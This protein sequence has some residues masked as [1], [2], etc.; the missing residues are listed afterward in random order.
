[1]VLPRTTIPGHGPFSLKEF[2]DWLSGGYRFDLVQ[3]GR[4]GDPIPMTDLVRE[5]DGFFYTRAE[6]IEHYGGTDEWDAAG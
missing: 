1:M 6:F 4:N 2:V 3:R 5:D